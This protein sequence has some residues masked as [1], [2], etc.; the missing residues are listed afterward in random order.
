M[1]IKES[2]PDL[3]LGHCQYLARSNAQCDK[4]TG[5]DRPYL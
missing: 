1:Y 2:K 3:L 4:V 5:R